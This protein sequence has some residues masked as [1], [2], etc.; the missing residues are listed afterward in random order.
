MFKNLEEELKLKKKGQ[1]VIVTRFERPSLNDYT[2]F[3]DFDFTS[4]NCRFFIYC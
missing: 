4:Y 2:F 3:T 1:D